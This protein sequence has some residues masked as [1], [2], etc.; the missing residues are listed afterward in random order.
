[1]EEAL[2]NITLENVENMVSNYNRNLESL[3]NKHAPVKTIKLRENHIVPWITDQLRDEIKLRRRMERN[4]QQKKNDL[5]YRAFLNQK[6][7]VNYKLK[8]I[9]SMPF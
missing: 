2:S 3:A 6:R 7:Y 9:L 1:M 5:N 4:W 8:G